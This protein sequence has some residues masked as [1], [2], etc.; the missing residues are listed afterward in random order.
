MEKLH[1]VCGAHIDPVWLWQRNEGIAATLSTFRC[2]ADFCEEYDGFVFNHNEA[3]LYEW[4]EEYEP[5]LFDRIRKLVE[6]G[7][8]C[9]MGGWYLQPDCV[10]PSGESLLAQIRLGQQYFLEKFG[11]T[12]KTAIN[13]DPFGHSRGLVQILKQT[14]Y[15]GYVF[16][17]PAEFQT[18]D[19]LWE[20]FD[21]SRIHAHGMMGAYNALLGDAANKIKREMTQ[22]DKTGAKSGMIFWGVGNH[23]GGPSRKDLDDIAVLIGRS[24]VEIFHSAPDRYMAQVDKQNLP[25]VSRSLIPFS[26]GCYTS[27]VRIK[28]ANRRLEN[29]LAVTEKIMS[30]AG[31]YEEHELIKA[32]KALAFCQ[33][34]DVLPGSSIRAVEE[35]SLQMLAYGEQITDT[36]YDKAFFRLCAGQ[37]KAKEDEIP[38]LVFNPHP[39]EIEGVFEVEFLLQN[40]N[41]QAGECTVAAVYDAEGR[42]L[43]SQNEKTRCSFN[44]DWVKKVSFRA[45]LKPSGV[46]RF[47][48]RLEVCK[49]E[50]FETYDQ[51]GTIEVSNDK[52]TVRISRKT[53]LIELYLVN[54]KTYLEN[55]GVLEMYEDNEDPWGM[56]VTGF[57]KK[58]DSFRLLSDKE[59]CAF[60]GY[61]EDKTPNVRIVEDGEVRM[62]VQAFFACGSN[63]AVVEYTIPKQGDYLDVDIT[64]YAAQPNRMF[65]YRL[66]SKLIGDPWGETAFGSQTLYDDEQESVYHKWCGIRGG[67]GQLYVLNRGTYG[68]SFTNSTM[69]L[70]LLRTATYSA[71]PI[72]DGGDGPLRK[73]AP[74]NRMNEHMDM[75]QRTFS[76]RITAAGDV[77]RQAQIFNE[78]PRA[79]SFFPSGEGRMQPSAITLD[80]PQVILSSVRGREMVLHNTCDTPVDAV[81][82]RT[83][84]K[85]VQMHFRPYELKIV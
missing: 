6:Q 74:E 18:G 82:A 37:P 9:I 43:P 73:L 81:I 58:L 75:G 44:L 41:W 10:M 22:I 13:V 26:V 42:Q 72:P 57:T 49:K 69:K 85:P 4:I 64:M 67:E 48:C 36:L 16:M 84:E 21:G 2:A 1:L 59:A 66:D 5:S 46:T 35:D 31:I 30:Y 25:V 33:F 79:L 34:H 15:E 56:F 54:G 45:K 61:P 8:W 11:K 65:K 19:F 40:Q 78:A 3:L 53:G 23:G 55:S 20:G 32:R 50:I 7:K 80:V 60:V 76:Y 12:P 70:S 51:T 62:K 39:Y 83:G 14:G 17:R 29:K 24:D 47:D 27:M 68:G 77:D 28:Q 71:H 63:T 38:I 52:M